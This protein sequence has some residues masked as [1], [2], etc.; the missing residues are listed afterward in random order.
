MAQPARTP[1]SPDQQH[2]TAA[3]QERRRPRLEILDAFDALQ[4]DE[5]LNAPE[6][7]E[8]DPCVKCNA[9]DHRRYRS[10]PRG[11]HHSEEYVDRRAAD[12]GL[13]TEPTARHNR[14]Q[15]RW[16]VRALS[17]ER[18]PTQYWKRYAVL[19][20][21]MRVQDH[22]DKHDRDAHQ[23]RDHRLPPVHARFDK[24]ARERIGG[25]D[26]AHTDPES[27]NIPGGP[28]SFFDGSGCEIAVP[29]WAMRNVSV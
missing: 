21:R 20:T 18:S 1:R 27:G 8:C 22:R 26:Y 4:N 12:P 17:S 2:K 24:P 5:N 23:D 29:E 11:K 28:G 3:K 14:A 15:H 9:E 19:R 25:D 6:Q 7:E 16:H 13:N 10:G